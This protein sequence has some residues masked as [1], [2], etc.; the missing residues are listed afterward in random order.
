[1]KSAVTAADN[2]KYKPVTYIVRQRKIQVGDVHR[3]REDENEE[4]I[5]SII[6][7]AHL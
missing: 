4:M 5:L 1:M 7:I 3:A 2:A 6:D